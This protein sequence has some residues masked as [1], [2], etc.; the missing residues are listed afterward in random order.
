MRVQYKRLIQNRAVRVKIMRL[1]SFIPDGWMIRVQY[2]IKTGRWPNL[3][4]P[5]RYTEKLQWYKLNYRD[6]LMA[7]CADKYAVRDYVKQAGLAH[8][9]NPIYGIYER[10][11]QVDWDTLPQQFVAKDTLGGGG[12]D[13]LI[14][15]DKSAL[16]K[17]R[18]Y[19]TLA[20]WV[21]PVQGKHP[22][23][24]W[25]YDNARHRILIEAYIPSDPEKGGLIDY[26]F[27][28]FAGKAEYLYVIAD[29]SVGSDAKL[30]IFTKSFERLPYE[31]MD[32]K[33]LNRN[34]PRPKNYSDMLAYAQR[35]AAPFPHARIDL[36]DQDEIIRFGE[37]TFFDG[38]G[39]MTFFP[40]QFDNE[41]GE[42]FLLYAKN[43]P[44]I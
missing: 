44:A 7:Q 3:R 6:P 16:D 25:V 30:G 37:I 12:N 42:K 4:E 9:L 24:E 41:L 8:I 34:I 27:F 40:D 1:L 11:E 21:E 29:R 26:K 15:R 5:H 14:C 39:Y 19:A 33:P 17:N 22:G 31:R 13:I 28:C 23:R 18:F 10:P 20:R 35:L 38:S 32:E 43:A 2:R 36:Y